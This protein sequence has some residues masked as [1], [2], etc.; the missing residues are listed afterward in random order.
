MYMEGSVRLYE[1]IRCITTSYSLKV[2]NM[3]QLGEI[4]RVALLTLYPIF[5][6][7]KIIFRND[8]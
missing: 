8:E 6:I 4:E 3:L 2:S 7:W 1:S 5:W